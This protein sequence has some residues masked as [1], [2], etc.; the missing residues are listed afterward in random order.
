MNND[1]IQTIERPTRQESKRSL[2][3][4]SSQMPHR[5]LTSRRAWRWWIPSGTKNQAPLTIAG[6]IG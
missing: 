3:L 4:D 6:R 2:D 5:R 1:E